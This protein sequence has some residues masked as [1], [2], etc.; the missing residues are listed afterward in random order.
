VRDEEF[1]GVHLKWLVALITLSPWMHYLQGPEGPSD[2][3]NYRMFNRLRT[4]QLST[5][6]LWKSMITSQFPS[7]DCCHFFLKILMTSH[8]LHAHDCVTVA[9]YLP[10][11]HQSDTAF[12]PTIL[13]SAGRV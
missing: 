4:V 3:N 11:S 1:A 6:H 5:R 12:K 10:V 13:M 7:I 9:Q 8:D 2:I